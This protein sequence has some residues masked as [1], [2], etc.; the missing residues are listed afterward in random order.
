MIRLRLE[1]EAQKGMEL[2]DF[3]ARHRKKG[4]P[5]LQPLDFYQMIREVVPDATGLDRHIDGLYFLCKSSLFRGVSMARL[6]RILQLTREIDR[7]SLTIRL[8]IHPTSICLSDP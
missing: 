4:Q 1:E 2:S 7:L 5:F 8:S 3:F 6:T